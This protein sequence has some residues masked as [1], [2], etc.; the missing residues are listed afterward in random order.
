MTSSRPA[1]GNAALPAFLVER[2]LP[3]AAVATLAASV[4]RLATVC[5]A[6]GLGVHYLQAAHLRA[7]DTCF[8][9]FQAPSADAVRRVNVA[10]DF[11]FDRITEAVLLNCS[12]GV[13]A[14]TPVGDADG[15]RDRWP[16]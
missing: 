7:D 16:R 11:P 6:S 8:C 3:A 13:V 4:A 10:A 2:Y 14:G 9:L 1:A 5:A 15:S 12:D